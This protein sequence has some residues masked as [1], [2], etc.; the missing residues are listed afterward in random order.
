MAS[1]SSDTTIKLWNVETWTKPNLEVE[2][3][4]DDNDKET[5]DSK[6]NKNN[7]NANDETEPITLY[8]HSD[9]VQVCSFEELLITL[10]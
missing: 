9:Y 10:K 7:D 8:G 1:C 2:E 3:Q 4:N 5:T 6:E